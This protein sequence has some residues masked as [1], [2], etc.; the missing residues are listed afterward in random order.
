M[1]K[2]TSFSKLVQCVGDLD[3]WDTLGKQS[4]DGTYACDRLAGDLIFCKILPSSPELAIVTFDER[5]LL[6]VSLSGYGASPSTVL[7]LVTL[8]EAFTTVGS[9]GLVS[10][11][12][13]KYVKF[14]KYNFCDHAI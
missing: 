11:T 7:A 13:E 12:F 2:N 1:V 8:V 14:T 9:A 3:K 4:L 5:L 6:W 10:L